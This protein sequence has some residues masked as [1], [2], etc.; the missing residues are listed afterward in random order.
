MDAS[1]MTAS[2]LLT[3]LLTA[4]VSTA[5]VAS[6]NAASTG[7]RPKS[8]CID[9]LNVEAWDGSGFYVAGVL[10]W[11]QNPNACYSKGDSFRFCDEAADGWGVK[12]VLVGWNRS[13]TTQGHSSP[14]CPGWSNGD[15]PEGQSYNIDTYLVKGTTTKFIETRTVRN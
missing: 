15:L 2:A 14:Y 13:T 10:D 11:N 4:T 3:T 7:V 6:A 12:A 1:R 9:T 5:G 8:D